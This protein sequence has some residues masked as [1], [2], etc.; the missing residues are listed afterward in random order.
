MRYK[1]LLLAGLL[2]ILVTLSS[3]Q[4]QIKNGYLAG[5]SEKLCGERAAI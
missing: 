5:C 1:N 2:A 3:A 4:S